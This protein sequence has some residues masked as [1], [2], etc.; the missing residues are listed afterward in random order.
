VDCGAGVNSTLV[1]LRGCIVPL[2][3]HAIGVVDGV[4]VVVSGVPSPGGMFSFPLD[5]VVFVSEETSA[6]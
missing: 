6:S 1:P 2:T 5:V 4:V 3:P